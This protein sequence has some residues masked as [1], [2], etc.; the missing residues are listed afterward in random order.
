[1]LRIYPHIIRLLRLLKPVFDKIAQHDSDLARQGRRAGSSIALNTAEGGGLTGGNR[2]MRYKTALGSAREVWCVCDIGEAL[3]YVT[4]SDEIRD[5]LDMI[6][7]TLVN[8][9]K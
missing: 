3:G 9:T 8:V 7:A 6:I 4:V 1:M 5:L 2:R